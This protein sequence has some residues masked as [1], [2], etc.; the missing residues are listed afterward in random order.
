MKIQLSDHFSYRKL[1]K[2]TLPTIAIM[3]FTSIY[4]VVDG[5]FVS[6]CVGIDAFA[7]VNLIMPIIM[8]LGSVGFMIGTGGSAIVSKRHWE[9][10]KKEKANEYFSMLVYLCVVSGVILSVIGIIFTGPIA[11]L[12]GAKGSIAKD[13]VTYG[14]TVFLC[15][16]AC[17]AK[18]IPEFSCCCRKAQAWTV[19]NAT[20][21][22]Y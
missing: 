4:G 18:C 20:C 16:R 3:I 2:F 5:V 19:C 10:A 17:F 13:C 1:I 11:V 21:R 15:L 14:R 6:N 8:I 22:I 7:A 12:L 9:K